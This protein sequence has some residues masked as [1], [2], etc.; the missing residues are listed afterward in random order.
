M[1]LNKIKVRLIRTQNKNIAR[2]GNTSVY[3]PNIRINK[4]LDG[5]FLLFTNFSNIIENSVIIKFKGII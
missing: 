5:D 3:A 2:I 1:Q 4:T